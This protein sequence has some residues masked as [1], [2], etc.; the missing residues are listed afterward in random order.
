[1]L[2]LSFVGTTLGGVP[3]LQARSRAGSLLHLVITT[4]ELSCHVR[5]GWIVE[6]LKCQ[7]VRSPPGVVSVRTYPN[8]ENKII[9]LKSKRAKINKESKI[10]RKQEVFQQRVWRNV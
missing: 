5:S 9:K 10:V 8:N 3:G 7:L 1:M 6:N 2:S 4:A